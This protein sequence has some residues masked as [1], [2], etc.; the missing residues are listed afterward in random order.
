VHAHTGA[1][2]LNLFGR[3][4]NHDGLDVTDSVT[5]GSA[6]QGTLRL[7]IDLG[8]GA[9]DVERPDT[10]IPLSPFSPPQA[11]TPPAPPTTAALQ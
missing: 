5:S 10:V 4:R 2:E 11:P 1:G 8:A 3:H 6:Q 9:V 7:N